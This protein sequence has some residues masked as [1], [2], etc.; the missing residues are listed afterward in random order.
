M[1]KKQIKAFTFYAMLVVIFIFVIIFLTFPKFLFIDKKLLEK[2][3]YL[4]ADSVEEGITHLRLK[5][6]N[7]YDRTSRLVSFDFFEL[8]IGFLRLN[9]SGVCEGKNLKGEWSPWVIKLKAQDF[10]CF[11][12]AESITADITL[13]DG[14]YGTL[15]LRGLKVQDSILDQLSIDMRGRV[16]TARAKFMGFE[17]VGDGQIVF[18]PSNPLSSKLNG[19]VSGSGIKFTLSGT[20]EKLQL[21]R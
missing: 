17:L 15:V 1:I 10:T 4:T 9:F 3:L 12:L 16:F 21:Q 19:Q 7:L 6:V 18:N 2:G 8:S 13:K 14:I 11:S 20:L 5:K